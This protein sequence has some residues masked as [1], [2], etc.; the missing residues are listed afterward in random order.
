M[1]IG[2]GRGLGGQRGNGSTSR[3]DHR[4]RTANKVR[5]QGRQLIS[6][7]LSP[8]VLDRYVL[9]LNIAGFLQALAKRGEIICSGVARGPAAE[10]PDHRHGRLLR[11]RRER[12]GCR[13]TGE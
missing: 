4:H 5:R 3:G 2:G 12:P 11:P 6:S 8:T 10:V 13:R 1:G 7:I 9:A